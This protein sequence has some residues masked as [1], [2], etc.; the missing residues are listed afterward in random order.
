MEVEE[1]KDIVE[2]EETETAGIELKED[3]D[4]GMQSIRKYGPKNRRHGHLCMLYINELEGKF[5]DNCECV[6]AALGE[7]YCLDCMNVE[8]RKE[9]GLLS[10]LFDYG[11]EEY[12][13]E[14]NGMQQELMDLWE[15]CQ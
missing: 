10:Y 7:Q 4:D 14:Y 11:G 12:N 13:E 1:K 5:C 8:N 2:L 3:M 15:G 9:C 6:L